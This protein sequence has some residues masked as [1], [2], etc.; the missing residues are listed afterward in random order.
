M[1]KLQTHL[2]SSVPEECDPARRCIKSRA[3]DRCG[4]LA[5]FVFIKRS[6]TAVHMALCCSAAAART[7]RLDNRPLSPRFFGSGG[8]IDWRLA[9]APDNAAHPPNARLLAEPATSVGTV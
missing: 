6:G 4:R 8:L 7:P 1:L 3:I 9:P 2:G 5:A